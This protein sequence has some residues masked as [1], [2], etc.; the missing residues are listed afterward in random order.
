MSDREN[1]KN[2]EDADLQEQHVTAD[3]DEQELVADE[4]AENEK[5]DAA[6]ELTEMKDK[7]VRLMAEFENFRRRTARERIEL[8]KTATEDVMTALLPVIDDMERARQSIETTADANA[9][10][11]GFE[12]VFQK[13]QNVTQQK[14]LKVMEI[15]AG[16][17]F[18]SDFQEAVTQIPAPT[19]ELKGKIVDVIEKGY[20]LNDKVIRFAKVITGA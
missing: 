18:D 1:I 13:L 15:G 10:I 4:A 11:Q 12:L 6:A 17:E 7:Y 19:E 16:H 20:T 14:G 9:V 8:S 3:A 2:Q 5:D